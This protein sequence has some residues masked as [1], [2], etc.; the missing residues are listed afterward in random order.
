[1]IVVENSKD[2]ENHK[3]KKFLFKNHLKSSH[4]L[5]HFECFVN[6]PNTHTG[7]IH[8]FT[9]QCHA[10]CAILPT[11]FHPKHLPIILKHFSF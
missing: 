5:N 6:T 1:M 9:Q 3:A 7:E 11:V 10:Q 8:N 4:I 2:T